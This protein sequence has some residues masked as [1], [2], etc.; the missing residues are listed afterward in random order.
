MGDNFPQCQLAGAKIMFDEILRQIARVPDWRLDGGNKL[1]FTADGLTLRCEATEPALYALRTK[2]VGARAYRTTRRE[3]K[4][5]AFTAIGGPWSGAELYLT[6]RP[7]DRTTCAPTGAA[8]TL[9]FRIG[10]FKGCYE[11]SSASP[12]LRWRPAP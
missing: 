10:A 6:P 9:Q 3:C 2:L 11:Y 4:P 5:V 8:A 12:F 7:A 1:I